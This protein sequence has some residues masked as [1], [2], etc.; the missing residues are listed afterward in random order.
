[1]RHAHMKAGGLV[2]KIHLNATR[3]YNFFGLK[4]LQES[5]LKYMLHS[6]ADSCILYA[7]V[8]FHHMEK[9]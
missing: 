8:V 6:A 3:V 9:S 2:L 4:L 1:M 5:S 7:L